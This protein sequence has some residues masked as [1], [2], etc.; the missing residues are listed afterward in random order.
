[1][2]LARWI[3]DT[4]QVAEHPKSCALCDSPSSSTAHPTH[5]FILPPSSH[6]PTYPPHRSSTHPASPHLWGT[7]LQS[8]GSSPQ[9]ITVQRQI[10]KLQQLPC[11]ESPPHARHF[12]YIS[13]WETIYKQTGFKLPHFTGLECSADRLNHLSRVT[14]LRGDKTEFKPRWSDAAPH[15]W[16]LL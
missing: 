14:Q 2:T 1:M 15:F 11:I 10:G 9:D 4:L 7:Y 8:T 6:S 3:S 16:E 13:T 12:T 5:P